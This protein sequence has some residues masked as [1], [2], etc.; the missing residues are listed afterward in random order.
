MEKR[1]KK[2]DP[3]VIKEF[4]TEKDLGVPKMPNAGVRVGDLDDF[5]SRIRNDEDPKYWQEIW[6]K[7]KL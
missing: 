3:F 2:H 5:F 7:V 4:I 1:I 6:E